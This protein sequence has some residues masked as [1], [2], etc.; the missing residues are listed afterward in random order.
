MFNRKPKV[1][2]LIFFPHGN[3]Y[4][5]LKDF[6]HVMFFLWFHSQ[7]FAVNYFKFLKPWSIYHITHLEE[8]IRF[9]WSERGRNNIGR[10]CHGYPDVPVLFRLAPCDSLCKA[11]LYSRAALPLQEG[12]SQL[13]PVPIPELQARRR[14][15]GRWPGLQLKS[16]T[17]QR[18]PRWVWVLQHLLRLLLFAF[19]LPPARPCLVAF[20]GEILQRPQEHQRFAK[21]SREETRGA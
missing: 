18:R 7:V 10:T 13:S 16:E 1:W 11:R 8:S 14:E 4:S 17:W 2:N 3:G 19:S 6:I 9:E 20:R 12:K 5:T 15:G 21:I